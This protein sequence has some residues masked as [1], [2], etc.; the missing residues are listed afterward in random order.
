MYGLWPSNPQ[1]TEKDI[2][3]NTL[4]DKVVVITGGNSGIG[5]ETAKVLA[6]NTE[7]YEFIYGLG[8][9]KSLLRL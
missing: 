1:F 2:S 9:D 5:Y 8:I 6:G 7:A 4:K 3:S